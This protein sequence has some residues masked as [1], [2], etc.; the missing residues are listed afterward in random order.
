MSVVTENNVIVMHR[1][2]GYVVDT[3]SR[4]WRLKPEKNSMASTR[5]SSSVSEAEVTLIM[6]PTR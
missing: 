5:D 6:P 2:V 4:S 1:V 3:P